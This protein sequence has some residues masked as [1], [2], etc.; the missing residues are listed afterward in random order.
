MCS[1]AS[2]ANGHQHKAGCVAFS[3][4]RGGRLFI[5]LSSGGHWQFAGSGAC[6]PSLHVIIPTPR[7]RFSVGP[8]ETFILG[9]RR[10]PNA[11][12]AQIALYTLEQY[13][14]EARRT[15]TAKLFASRASQ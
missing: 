13:A 1:F 10:H 14:K 5:R 9:E 8:A 15:T 11:A 2:L 12:A 4:G 7:A 3:G 6:R